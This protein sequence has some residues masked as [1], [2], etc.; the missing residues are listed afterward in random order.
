MKIVVVFSPLTADKLGITAIVDTPVLESTVFSLPLTVTFK[1]SVTV[2]FSNVVFPVFVIIIVYSTISPGLTL[3]FCASTNSA[4][5]FTFILV[6]VLLIV[7]DF[8]SSTGTSFSS[9]SVTVS[10]VLSGSVGIVSPVATASL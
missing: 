5:S 7:N 9:L 6:A 3:T 8:T 2:I 10:G 1:E 4:L